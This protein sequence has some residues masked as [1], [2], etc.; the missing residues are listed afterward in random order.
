MVAKVSAKNVPNAALLSL[1]IDK[2]E[3]CFLNVLR[4]PLLIES[5]TCPLLVKPVIVTV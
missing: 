3:L 5:G 1:V 2:T 4:V